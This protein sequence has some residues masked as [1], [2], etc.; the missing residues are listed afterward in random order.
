M[1]TNTKI[2]LAAAFVLGAASAALAS[3]IVANPSSA[4]SAREWA[5]YLGHKQKH[6]N[7]FASN[8]CPALEGY[9]DCHPDDIALWPQYSTTGES[10]AQ[11]KSHAKFKEIR[12]E[13]KPEGGGTI[14]A[15]M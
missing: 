8:T 6:E 4:Q 11:K 2:A 15:P 5:Q 9:P 12:R 14:P 10:M 13:R 1:F 7:A 3:D